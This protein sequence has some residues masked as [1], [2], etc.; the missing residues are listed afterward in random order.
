MASKN[1]VGQRLFER[2]FGEEQ[3]NAVPCH[4]GGGQKVEYHDWKTASDSSS[5][6]IFHFGV[7]L[8]KKYLTYSF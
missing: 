3:W 1:G 4:R 5:F 7:H 2:T 8:N 6:Q